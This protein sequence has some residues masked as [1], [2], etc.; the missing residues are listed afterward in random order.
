MLT[1]LGIP[2][3]LRQG[4]NSRLPAGVS[5][6]WCQPV[7]E[8]FHARYSAR[9]RR[10]RY[11]IINRPVRPAMRCTSV[12]PLQQSIVVASSGKSAVAS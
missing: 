4:G 1:L 2:G 10:Y 5:L 3:A 8:D 7:A 12:G 9:A 6:L 11:T